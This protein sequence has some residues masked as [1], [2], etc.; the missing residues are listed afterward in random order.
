MQLAYTGASKYIDQL[1]HDGQQVFSTGNHATVHTGQ[2]LTHRPGVHKI[3]EHPNQPGDM[4]TVQE[5][6]DYR[7][8]LSMAG[9]FSP[10]IPTIDPPNHRSPL[11]G[12]LQKAIEFSFAAGVK[13]TGAYCLEGQ[14]TMTIPLCIVYRR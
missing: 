3:V 6:M 14:G 9:T 10:S 2:Q 13:G 4:I 5:P 11:R 1:W 12:A 8:K 7:L